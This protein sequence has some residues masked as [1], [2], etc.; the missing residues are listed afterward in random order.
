MTDTMK[1]QS[2]S[3][4]S[5]L[6]DPGTRP[7]SR[8]QWSARSSTPSKS[9]LS[10]SFSSP[11]PPPGLPVTARSSLMF[12]SFCWRIYRRFWSPALAASSFSWL[13]TFI[14]L[15]F[16][17]SFCLAGPK[18]RRAWNKSKAWKPGNSNSTFLITSHCAS[19]VV[20]ILTEFSPCAIT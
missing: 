13:S 17:T 7:T 8:K 11:P 10:P 16:W 4:T 15:C 3:V 9:G 1:M 5:V 2:R 18:V 19:S 20:I 6:S 14:C 12:C